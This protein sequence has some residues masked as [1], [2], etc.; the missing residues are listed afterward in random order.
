MNK[1]KIFKNIKDIL[2]F[3]NNLDERYKELIDTA[4]EHIKSKL[5]KNVDKNS[6][7][8]TMFCTYL[9]NYWIVLENCANSKSDRFSGNGYT[10]SKNTKIEHDNAL[11]LLNHWR[12]EAAD[13]IVDQKF[14]ISAIKGN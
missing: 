7:V 9:V 5:K 10:I 11:N 4:E 13:L 2:H 12:A 8:L 3:D 14:N 6:Y 1:E